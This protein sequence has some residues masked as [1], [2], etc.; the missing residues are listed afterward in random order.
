MH[1]DDSQPSD[2]RLGLLVAGALFAALLAVH[3]GHMYSIDGLEYYR[4]ADRLVTA[5]SVTFD[6][7]IVWAPGAGI[8]APG[9]PPGFAF[10]LAPAVALASGLRTFQPPLTTSPYDMRLLYGDLLYAAASW[11]NPLLASLT[12][13]IVVALVRR[14]GAG[15]RLAAV[16]GFATVLSGPLL[17]YARADFAQP[18][19]AFLLAAGVLVVVRVRSGG[20]GGWWLVPIVAWAVMTRPV[21]GALTAAVIA[22]GLLVPDARPG[23]VRPRPRDLAMPGLGFVAG[24]AVNLIVNAARRGNPLS[25]GYGDGVTGFLPTG[26]L[27]Y[28]VSPGRALV[29]YLPLTVLAAVGAVA[30]WRARE[31][32][33]LVVL[34]LPFALWFLVYAKWVGLSGWAYGPRFLIPLVP[35]AVSLAVVAVARRPS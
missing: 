16:A 8:R 11:V 23:L 6:P 32:L 19:A 12:A 10:A 14:L 26:L 22:A 28:L 2:R 31:R 17:W 27:A 5:G 7:P 30:L 13:A 20:G 9:G 24:I 29:W 35:L 1:D 34:G 15:L 25:F 4:S 21:D 18:L 33:S 3:S